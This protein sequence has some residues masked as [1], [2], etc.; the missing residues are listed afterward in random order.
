VPHYPAHIA[1]PVT[2]AIGMNIHSDEGIPV[3]DS[4]ADGFFQQN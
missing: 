4:L 3:L 2:E 1:R